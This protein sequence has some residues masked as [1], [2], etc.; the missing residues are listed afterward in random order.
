[1]LD[2]TVQQQATGAL[3]ML[4]DLALMGCS[5]GAMGAQL[6]N[7]VVLTELTYEQAGVMSDS[8]LGMSLRA[9]M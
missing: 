9:S 3:S 7:N 8:Y 4:Q 1:M 6:W 2:W 5:A